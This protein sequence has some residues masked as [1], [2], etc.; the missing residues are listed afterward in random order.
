VCF[1]C[2]ILLKKTEHV[3]QD[4]DAKG[5]FWVLNPLDVDSKVPQSSDH[6]GLP[7]ACLWLSGE[8]VRPM[9]GWGFI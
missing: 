5:L 7:L 3:G 9:A 2:G 8:L 1:Y 4:N 6:A